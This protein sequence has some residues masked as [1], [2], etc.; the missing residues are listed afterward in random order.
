MSARCS[1]SKFCDCACHQ[2]GFVAFDGQQVAHHFGFGLLA[3]F[4][5][6][7]GRII[8]FLGYEGIQAGEK[9]ICP[10]DPFFTPLADQA[11]LKLGNTAHDGEH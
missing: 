11:A 7:R 10:L 8:C 9:C 3:R 1:T 4:M 2:R 5:R 6:Q